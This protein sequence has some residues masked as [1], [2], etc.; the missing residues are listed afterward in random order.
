[1]YVYI[2]IRNN[3]KVWSPMWEKNNCLAGLKFP[4]VLCHKNVYY[5]KDSSRS[6]CYVVSTGK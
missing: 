1:M 2:Y 6:N 5:Y 4:K 3:P